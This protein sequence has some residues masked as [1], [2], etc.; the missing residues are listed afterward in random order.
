MDGQT[1]RMCR[2][3]C[4]LFVSMQR[5]QVSHDKSKYHVD[6]EVFAACFLEA[7]PLTTIE[8]TMMNLNRPGGTHDFRD[9]NLDGSDV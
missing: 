4:I 1:A 6:R 8:S 5:N 7:R 2:Q 9:G 3:I